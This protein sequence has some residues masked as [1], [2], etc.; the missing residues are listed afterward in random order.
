MWLKNAWYAA[1]WTPELARTPLKRTILETNIVLYRRENGSPAA[2]LDACPH[3]KAPL[4]L[5]T[6]RGDDLQC[7]YHGLRFDGS[8]RC[9]HSPHADGH[10]PSRMSVQAFPLAERHGLVWLWMG[11]PALADES[12]IPD[13]SFH[14]D[15]TLG[16][17]GGTI[18]MNAHYELITD[19]LLDLSH[20]EF[21]HAAILD[22]GAVL[23]GEFVIDQRGNTV[24]ANRVMPACQPFPLYKRMLEKGRGLEAAPDAVDQWM[25][26][27]WDAPAHIVIA[28]GA[29][30]CGGSRDVGSMVYGS[31]MLTPIN[32]TSTYYFW[33]ATRSYAVGDA[34]E[35]A[36]WRET[37]RVAFE[38]QDQPMI[39]AQQRSLGT[40][41]LLDSKPVMFTIDRAPQR[42]RKVLG[43]LIARE[44]AMRN[45]SAEADDQAVA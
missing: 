30:L 33:G 24:H 20:V 23:G 41:P 13:F 2:L 19:N 39:E 35:D 26:I 42:V 16:F 25:D 3:R 1:V 37:I 14:T 45:A 28:Q 21:L 40:T 34:E 6:V 22:G 36:F 12:A 4:S 27:R 5:G 44:A 29:T 31:D 43:E 8:G 15:P 7:G 18:V 17:V 32:A 38:E 10:I 9:V 11:E